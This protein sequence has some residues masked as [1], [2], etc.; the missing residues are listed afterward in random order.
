MPHNHERTW[1]LYD[2]IVRFSE[3]DLFITVKPSCYDRFDLFWHALT[4]FDNSFKIFWCSMRYSHRSCSLAGTV[5]RLNIRYLALLDNLTLCQVPK[6]YC[7]GLGSTVCLRCYRQYCIPLVQEQRKD[8]KPSLHWVRDDPESA[9]SIVIKN[10]W[11][12]EWLAEPIAN[13]SNL[14][15]ILGGGGIIGQRRN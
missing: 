13:I 12:Q 14:T 15:H 11:R 8:Y 3:N 4:K 10:K 2:W 5:D 1:Q 6:L 7:L 9:S